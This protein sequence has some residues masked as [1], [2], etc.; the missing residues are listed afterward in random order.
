MGP[1]ETESSPRLNLV[2][3]KV[4]T[5]N[6]DLLTRP[7][8]ACSLLTDGLNAA[9]ILP[10]AS[11]FF[12]FYSQLMICAYFLFFLH[13]TLSQASVWRVLMRHAHSLSVFEV[14]LN[15]CGSL[16]AGSCMCTLCPAFIKSLK[17]WRLIDNDVTHYSVALRCLER[18]L[19]RIKCIFIKHEEDVEKILFIL[20]PPPPQKK[21]PKG[22][23]LLKR[24]T[25]LI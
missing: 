8:V 20:L 11:F 24:C 25:K 14:L 12:F 6:L 17:L 5:Q 15:C 9:L 1:A 22:L 3:S 7:N 13:S 16:V 19:N 4:L 23:L 2:G 21:N 10:R 18:R